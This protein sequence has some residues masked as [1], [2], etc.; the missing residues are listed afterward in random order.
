MSM[1]GSTASFLSSGAEF[2]NTY[3]NEIITGPGSLNSSLGLTTI[4]GASFKNAPYADR[5]DTMTYKELKTYIEM[6]R[7][8][9]CIYDSFGRITDRIKIQISY[10]Y[11]AYTGHFE[12]F[13]VQESASTPF[14]F[15]YSATF[16][17]EKV[18]Y[19]FI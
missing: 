12:S 8:N 15:T 7:S 4:P 9:G 6:V 10:D 1:Q 3:T 11:A 16:K 17:V 13:D 19:S 2:N 5:K 14:K 18:L